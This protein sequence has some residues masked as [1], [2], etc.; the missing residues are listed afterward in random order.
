[1]SFSSFQLDESLIHA[2]QTN[3]K[4]PST[5][6]FN[7]EPIVHGGSDREF[8]R[9]RSPNGK[10][11]I[12]MRYSKEREENSLYVKVAG[13]MREI[14]L[15]VPE[16]V[17][18]DEV[19]C[20]TILEDLGNINLYQV[21]RDPNSSKARVESLYQAALNQAQVLH[22]YKE[23]SIPLMKGFD[24][25]LYHW[26]RTY[27][28]ENLVARWAAICLEPSRLVALELEGEKMVSQLMKQPRGLIHRDF[29]SQNLVVR[30]K[31]VWLIDFQG[32][33]LG[34]AAYDVASLLYDPYVNLDDSQRTSLL[35][36]YIASAKKNQEE[37]QDQFYRVAIQR[38]MQALGAYGYLGL[39]KQ[40]Q[41]FLKYIAPGLDRLAE[42]L[43][44]LGG[45]EQTL[46]LT[47]ECKEKCR[48]K[49]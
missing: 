6:S 8:Y 33:R 12:V 43:I 34:H 27:F 7:W 39:V 49:V 40:K 5:I 44:R 4:D 48:Q 28:L 24:E 18:H 41:D 1:M 36:F 45:M 25:K 17:F 26:E 20:L 3:L 9:V 29:Q 30:D 19:L 22:Q 46:F 16:I 15:N 35:K 42:V 47:L 2:V 38:L 21:V 14:H 11:W 37:F 31:T 10:S 13:F 23:T 32:M